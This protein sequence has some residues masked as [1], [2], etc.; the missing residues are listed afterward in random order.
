MSVVGQVEIDPVCR[1]VLARHWPHVPRHDD[2]RTAIGWWRGEERPRV[3]LVCGGFPCQPFSNAGRRRGIADSRWGWPW[4]EHVV[5][6]LRPRYVLVENVAALV[7]DSIAFGWLLGDLAALGFDA[8]WSLLSAY[9]LGAPHMR[10][11]LLLMAHPH[12]VDGSQGLGCHRQRKPVPPLHRA[13]GTWGNPVDRTLEAAARPDRV[14]DGLAGRMV[15]AGG[16]AVV[17]ALAEHLGR[18]ILTADHRVH[19]QDI[20]SRAA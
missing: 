7:D 4:M 3:D 9:A 1:S 12:S 8:Q 20:S 6:V 14:P 17:P 2:V 19:T 16:N 13:A 5:R 11:R 10:N 15:A 18:L